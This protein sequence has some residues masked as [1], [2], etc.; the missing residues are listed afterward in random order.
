M[1]IFIDDPDGA[2]ITTPRDEW[3]IFCSLSP[4]PTGTT[5]PG[6][7]FLSPAIFKAIRCGNILGKNSGKRSYL[8]FSMIEIVDDADIGHVR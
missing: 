1:G 8:E 3:I 6:F 7:P 4:S 2:V 5:L